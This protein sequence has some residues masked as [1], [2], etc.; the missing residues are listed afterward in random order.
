MEIGTNSYDNLVNELNDFIQS[1]KNH[2]YESA[3]FTL[4]TNLRDN[5]Q[6]KAL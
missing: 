5:L 1:I 2:D 3:Y 4:D 6:E